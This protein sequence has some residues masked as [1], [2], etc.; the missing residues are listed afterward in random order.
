[1]RAVTPRHP[2]PPTPDTIALDR[3]TQ[4]GGNDPGH[5]ERS[6]NLARWK[7][8][9]IP[10]RCLAEPRHDRTGASLDKSCCGNTLAS[11]CPQIQR[12]SADTRPPMPPRLVRSVVP[13]HHGAVG[14]NQ[15]VAEALDL[16]E[17][18]LGTGVRVEVGGVVDG[19]LLA[20]ERGLD[21]E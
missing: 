19:V 7:P 4:Q 20:H 9:A 5:S 11:R 10:A 14:F 13:R 17:G 18:Q 2:L 3:R 6:E 1:M 12:C 21:G 8:L 15:V 16:V